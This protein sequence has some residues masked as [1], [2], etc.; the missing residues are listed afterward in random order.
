[1]TINLGN[2]FIDGINFPL[3]DSSEGGHSIINDNAVL[4]ETIKVYEEPSIHFNKV[5]DAR[6]KVLPH[7][8]FN[9]RAAETEWT[10]D[11]WVYFKG[12]PD[13]S[14]MSLGSA[15]YSCLVISPHID[16]RQRILCMNS[17][18]SPWGTY[19]L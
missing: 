1:M 14:V 15:D 8:D 10:I 6:L 4:E 2:L 5:D 18:G 12:T 11:F 19:G 13:G 3:V 17:A 7:E 16:A 9:F